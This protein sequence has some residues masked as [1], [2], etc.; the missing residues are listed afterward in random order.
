[1]L[2]NS[3]VRARALCCIAA[4]LVV[5]VFAFLPSDGE[6]SFSAKMSLGLLLA[7]VVLWVGEPVPFAISGLAI[8]IGIP[9]F[10]ILP[11]QPGDGPTV[12]VEFISSVI[13]F[14]LASFGLSAALLKTKVPMKIVYALLKLSKGRTEGVLLAFMASTAC[15]S[16]FVSDI[17]CC[18]LFAGI[19]MSTILTFEEAEPGTSKLGRALMIAIPY[20][21]AIGGQAFP[22]GSSMNI[23]AIGLLES[24]T[25]VHISFLQWAAIC[26]PIA[27]ILLGA[28]WLS[29]CLVHKPE[30]ISQK[31]IDRVA[32][33]ATSEERLDSLD[34]KV[35]FVIGI[36]FA[37][38]ISSN[39]TGWDATGIAVFGLVLLFL[40]GIDVLDI[41]EYVASVSWNMLI[42]VGSMQ[43]LAGGMKEQ[44]AASWLLGSTVGKIGLGA[45]PLVCASSVMIPLMRLFIPV[46]PALIAIA[47]PPLCLLGA[48]AGIS[49]VFFTIVCAISA[50]TSLMNGLDS[51]SMIAYRYDYWNLVD[52]LKSG[53]LPTAV[54]MACHALM[55]LPLIHAVGL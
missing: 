27:V 43:A 25:G 28:A 19:A 24:L 46:G 7:G 35:L 40:P 14:I 32:E 53:L 54:L 10:G 49:P 2:K 26:A 21:A 41:D 13:F 20:A 3:S 39:W 29:I 48:E 52:Y 15:V 4:V 37:L 1:M 50:S 23:M 17:P 16:L 12:W 47:L 30:A 22:S 38:W 45:A 6:L 42:L 33:I 5:V 8:M 31:T 9:V 55:L 51:I 11:W 18:A 44:G 34:R 36:T